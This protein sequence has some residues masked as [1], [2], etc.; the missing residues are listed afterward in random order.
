MFF[1]GVMLLLIDY[2]KKLKTNK[3][4]NEKFKNKHINNDEYENNNENKNDDNDK[5]NVINLQSDLEINKQIYENAE[6]EDG[7]LNNIPE[8]F[9][10]NEKIGND[11]NEKLDNEHGFKYVSCKVKKEHKTLKCILKC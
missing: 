5:L 1:L 8:Q 2:L 4:R 11:K 3:E 7:K 10:K 9:T 6:K